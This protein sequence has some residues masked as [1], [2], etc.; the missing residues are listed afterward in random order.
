L[1]RSF[2][3]QRGSV[4]TWTGDPLTA[5]LDLTAIYTAVTPSFNLVQNEIVSL[6]LTDQNKFKE[7]LPF[8]ITLKMSGELMKPTITFDISLPPNV[9]TLWPDVDQRLQQ[10]RGE[11]SELNKQVFALL[12]LNQFVGE[13]PVES[14]AGGGAGG[15]SSVGNLAFQSASQILT[16]Q[17]DQLAGSLIKGVNI[18]FDLNNEQDFST[19][20]EIDY[21]E[22][23]IAV[24]K[25][26]FNERVEVSVGSN[27]DVVG[28]GAP[29]QNSSN[30]AG[31]VSVD[32]KLSKDGRYRLR[33]YRQNQYDEVVEGQVVETGLSFILTLDYNSLKELFHRS[34]ETKLIER[35]TIKPVS[36]TSSS[37]Q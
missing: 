22:L 21:T 28:V 31:D 12:L 9:L 18:H 16:N 27:F 2:A 26:L 6:P 5:T 36:A 7:K 32:Y 8:F 35:T 37:N 17:L 13:D 29:N 3:I 34:Q 23:D 15:G 20:N 10:I 1:K 14:V 4:I 30:L 11:E 19:G 24:S 25:K 33:A